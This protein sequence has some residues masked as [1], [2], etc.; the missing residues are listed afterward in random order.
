MQNL[1]IEQKK[2]LFRKNSYLFNVPPV[3]TVQWN[4]DNWINYIDRNGG[5]WITHAAKSIIDNNKANEP[6][7]NTGFFLWLKKNNTGTYIQDLKTYLKE[8]NFTI[9]TDLL[10]NY[11]VETLRH[12]C[13][14]F[15]F[16]K[17]RE[18]L[19]ESNN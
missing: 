17:T 19:N 7:A 11:T 13:D 14:H 9:G 18:L 2:Q 12:I 5:I 10:S 15:Y 16:L 3:P 8:A 4:E 1:S 6:I